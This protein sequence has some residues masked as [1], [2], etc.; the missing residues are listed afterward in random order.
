[1]KPY[2]SFKAA[3]SF[4]WCC[5]P[6]RRETVELADTELD[7]MK[8]KVSHSRNITTKSDMATM[9]TYKWS[10]DVSSHHSSSHEQNDWQDLQAYPKN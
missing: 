3:T 2:C 6:K 7:F 10:E 5:N 4:A 8:V 1:M 9:P